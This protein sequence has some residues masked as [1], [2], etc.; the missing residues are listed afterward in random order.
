MAT[1]YLLGTEVARAGHVDDERWNALSVS[2]AAT[3]ARAKKAL[4]D[5]GIFSK[6]S[7]NV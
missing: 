2:V 1:W 7:Q 3:M 6:T 5:E 4:R